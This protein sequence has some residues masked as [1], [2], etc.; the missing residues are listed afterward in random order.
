[1]IQLTVP[2][3]PDK[4][5]YLVDTNMFNYF[6]YKQVVQGSTY[7]PSPNSKV[8]M[9]PNYVPTWLNKPLLYWQYLPKYF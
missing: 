1:M 9:I 2:T 8:I 5:F 6:I 7:I 3:D 4:R